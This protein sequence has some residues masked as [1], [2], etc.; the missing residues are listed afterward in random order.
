[1]TRCVSELNPNIKKPF[2]MIKSSKSQNVEDE[3]VLEKCVERGHA[4]AFLRLFCGVDPI[5]V[6]SSQN[7]SF[8]RFGAICGGCH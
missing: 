6:G 7:G 1:M 3:V 2:L 5:G 4:S 8:G